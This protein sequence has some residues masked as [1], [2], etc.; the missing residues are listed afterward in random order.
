M[1]LLN[2]PSRE[3]VETWVKQKTSTDK[4]PM[5]EILDAMEAPTYMLCLSEMNKAVADLF[6]WLEPHDC[7]NPGCQQAPAHT[8][9]ADH[10][11][12]A[13]PKLQEAV[14]AVEEAIIEMC[15]DQLNCQCSWCKSRRLE[16]QAANN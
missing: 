13:T 6:S 8:G 3:E 7:T 9:Y 1:S 15:H 10:L 2:E 14:A 4:N 12:E 5:Q 16:S 11:R